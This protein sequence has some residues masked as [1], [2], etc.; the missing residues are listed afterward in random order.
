M[1]QDSNRFFNQHNKHLNEE[2]ISVCVDALHEDNIDLLPSSLITHVEHCTQCKQH[3]IE[4][5]DL[6]LDVKQCLDKD[7]SK[8]IPMYFEKIPSNQGDLKDP[9]N[10]VTNL[11]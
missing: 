10:R 5:H 9:D 4:V 8:V 6:L 2:G 1:T 3:I 11:F 7:C